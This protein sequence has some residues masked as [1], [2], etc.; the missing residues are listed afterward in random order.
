MVEMSEV[1]FDGGCGG[2]GV[3]DGGGNFVRKRVEVV[4]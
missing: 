1:E 4:R 3:E 2:G